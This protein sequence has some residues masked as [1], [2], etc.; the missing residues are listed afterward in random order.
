MWQPPSFPDL[1]GVE[2]KVYRSYWQDGLIDVFAGSGV[3]LIGISWLLDLVPIGA[4]VPAIMVPLWPLI[5]RKVVVP[6]AGQVTFSDDREHRMSTAVRGMAI[7]GVVLF[8]FLAGVALFRPEL[9]ARFDAALDGASPAIPALLLGFLMA[10]GGLLLGQLR[11][12]VYAIVFAVAGIVG[13]LLIME[14][15]W[16]ILASGA[17]VL[18]TGVPLLARFILR[19]P[20]S[21]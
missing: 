8:A 6:R 7:L 13:A 18:F 14:P 19:Y 9:G 12:F 5:R 11:G 20:L 3:V 4:A 21:N 1:A 17:V 16:T 15:G 10:M 2:E